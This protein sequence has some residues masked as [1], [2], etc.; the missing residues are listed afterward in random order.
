MPE[1]KP[2]ENDILIV[3]NP[4]VNCDVIDTEF[5]YPHK[6]Y[7]QVKWHGRPHRIPPGKTKRMP[8]FLAEHFAKH[9]ADHLLTK[10]EE[11]TGKQGLLN[12][13]QERPKIISQIL[14]G[15]DEWYLGDNETDAGQQ[16]E[17]MV[18]ELNPNDKAIDL[19]V[20]PNKVMGVLV[21]TPKIE[22]FK[23]PD[24][25]EEQPK[26]GEKSREDLIKECIDLGIEIK[27]SETLE[28]LT[29]KIKSF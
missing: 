15:V 22:D 7:F 25:P 4:D 29:D 11:E 16:V 24:K 9:L 18:E 27:G 21:E 14:I 20:V 13:P 1:N 2:H 3:A 5:G 17:D 12:H 10:K 23:E 6:D 8:R 28:Q 19:G 26:E